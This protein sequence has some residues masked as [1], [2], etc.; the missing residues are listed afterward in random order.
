MTTKH[1]RFTQH[2]LLNRRRHLFSLIPALLLMAACEKKASVEYAADSPESRG[3]FAT[4]TDSVAGSNQ[5]SETLAYEHTVSVELSKD[6][7]PEH[8]KAV[9]AACNSDKEYGCTILDVEISNTEDIPRGSVSMR[10]APTGVD[11]II[12]IAG[13]GGR[14]TA[15]TTHA[16]D[17]AA[18][19]AD[20]ERELALLT[21][22]RNRL[23]EFLKSKELKID[24]LITV[25]KELATVQ[26]QFDTLSTRRANL[27]RR[28]DTE[29][30]T[31]NMS[32]WRQ[33]YAAAQSPI[34][35][36]LHSFG[37]EFKQAI[38]GVIGFVAVLLPWL[39]IITPGIVLLRLFWRWITRW[40]NRREVR[41]A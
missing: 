20:T 36:S 12:A 9:Q 40:L 22:H 31:I 41:S 29:L 3:G 35:D 25:S 39:V 13:K 14:V 2:I 30:L 18:P 26:T 4:E 33:D 1:G 21:T 8:M 19:V 32:V 11:A 17:L 38:A 28:I 37:S 15:R 16:E 5:K 7:L 27:R 10:L 6:L 24:Q 34:S 23:E